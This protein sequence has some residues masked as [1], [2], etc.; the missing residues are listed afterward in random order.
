MHEQ[1]GIPDG[2][3][4]FVM[5]LHDSAGLTELHWHEELEFNLITSGSA[6]YVIDS[7]RYLLTSGTLIWL[8]PGQEHLLVDYTNSYTMWVVVFT[9]AVRDELAANPERR[10]MLRPDPGRILIRRLALGDYNRLDNLCAVVCQTTG[11]P[12]R[13]NTG[14]RFLATEGWHALL[15]GEKLQSGTDLS[16]VVAGTLR[17]IARA[18]GC[19][20][21]SEVAE[22]L[23][24]TPGWVSRSFHREMGLPFIAYCNRTRLMRF[25]SLRK[26]HP[27]TPITHLAY[28]AGFGS[29]AQFYRVYRKA[30]GRSPTQS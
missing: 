8:F 26:T 15:H 6:Y 16:P 21:L 20:A 12:D 7:R 19:V 30:H 27:G 11:A 18:G 10:D 14:V 1:L 23:N 5:K 13:F 4:G 9:R 24:S 29:Y 25:A 28:R 2:Q 3:E 22:Q 17:L